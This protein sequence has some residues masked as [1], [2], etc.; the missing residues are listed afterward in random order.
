MKI[1]PTIDLTGRYLKALDKRVTGNDTRESIIKNIISEWCSRYAEM[2]IAEEK[3]N[4]DNV[5]QALLNAEDATKN[6]LLAKLKAD[7]K[8]S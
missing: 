4:I 3:T 7:L 2:D 8:V 1:T 5:I 6:S